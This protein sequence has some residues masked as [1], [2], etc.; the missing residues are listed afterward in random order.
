MLVDE[1]SG[2]VEPYAALKY[3]F[4][5]ERPCHAVVGDEDLAELVPAVQ[6]NSA[7][8]LSSAHSPL[9]QI[10]DTKVVVIKLTY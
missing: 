4:E 1:V 2:F 9:Y 10:I 5:V 8:D 7:V 3:V 6:Y